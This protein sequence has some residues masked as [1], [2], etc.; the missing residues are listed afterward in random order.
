VVAQHS[1]ERSR[2][3]GGEDQPAPRENSAA[4]AIIDGEVLRDERG[5]ACALRISSRLDAGHNAHREKGRLFAANQLRGDR[6]GV[7]V[8]VLHPAYPGRVGVPTAKSE[9]GLRPIYHH[10]EDRGR[11][12]YWCASSRW[13]YG[14]RL[15][16]GCRKKDW[17]VALLRWSTKSP[18]ANQQW[19]TGNDPVNYTIPSLPINP[20]S[21]LRNSG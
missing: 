15:N 3:G 5:C 16:N 6:T 9:L 10:K 1:L 7:E 12:G 13:R 19:N 2:G 11:Y 8:D 21:E 20:F 18:V 4:A 17:A 14:V